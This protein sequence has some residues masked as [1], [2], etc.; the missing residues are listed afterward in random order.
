[1]NLFKS[2][3]SINIKGKNINRFIKKL[4]NCK[5]DILRIK[6]KNKNEVDII[7]KKE[8]YDKIKKIK[9]IYDITELEVFGLL[10]IKKNFRKNMHIIIIGIICFILFIILTQMIFEIEIIHSNKDIRD[11]LK[12]ELNQN[13]IKEL[14]IK[15]SYEEIEKLKE[16]ILNKYPNKI[17][18]LEIENKGT[19]YI[20]KV[21][22]RKINKVKGEESPRDIIAKKPGI[23]KKVIANHG[24]IVKDMDDYVEKGEVIISGDLIFNNEIKG[25]EKADG[26]VYAEIWYTTKTEYPLVID[27]VKKTGRIKNVY[28]IK[29]INNLYK[30]S[31]NKSKVK[32]ISEKTIASNK[33]IPLKL[34]KFKEEETKT[35]SQVLTYD[36]AI[37]KAKEASIKEIK[38]KLKKPEYIIRSSYLKSNVNNS[39]IEVEMFFAVYED[40]T[41][42]REIGDS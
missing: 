9:S 13:G 10:K 7:I 22:E 16:K 14:S 30:F 5:I 33:I 24:E 4:R 17:E 19:K 36:E 25:R 31:L 12:K 38:S 27:K 6:Y 34:V 18:W 11:L 1:M 23:I 37:E 8:D 28:G 21:E 41:D 15:K 39:T 26:K 29:F 40:I 32:I 35:I 2:R 42:Y 3:I 20:V